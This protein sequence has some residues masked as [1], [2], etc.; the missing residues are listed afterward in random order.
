MQIWEYAVLT[1]WRAKN[2]SIT[3]TYLHPEAP[4]SKVVQ[5]EGIFAKEPDYWAQLL[6]WITKLGSDGWEMTG[7][8]G[9]RPRYQY[10]FKR[11]KAE[12]RTE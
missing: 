1:W 8:V 4:Q 6:A 7:V 9:D 5:R 3:L 10:W 12:V 11:P 2:E